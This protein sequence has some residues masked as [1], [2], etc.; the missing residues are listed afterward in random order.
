MKI[1]QIILFDDSGKHYEIRLQ[2]HHN[3]AISYDVRENPIL[4]GGNM[5]VL[6][7]LRDQVITIVAG[8]ESIPIEKISNAIQKIIN[9]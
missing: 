1:T 8:P 9:K 5:I 3:V 4:F 7:E 6:D 2:E